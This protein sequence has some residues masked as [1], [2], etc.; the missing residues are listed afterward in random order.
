VTFCGNDG[1]LAQ[2]E[3][4]TTEAGEPT[5]KRY[6]PVRHPISQEQIDDIL[7]DELKDFSFPVKPIYNPRIRA[8][9]RAVGV[10]YP[11]GQQIRIQ[12]IEIGKQDSARKNFLVD[13]L[14][15][16]YYEAEIMRLQHVNELYKNLLAAGDTKR[17]RWINAQIDKFFSEKET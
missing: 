10:Y 3:R 12:K 6:S 17:H 5:M 4:D 8:N 7:A 13:T 2:Q 11:G 16:E 15:H 1:I 9:G 14:L